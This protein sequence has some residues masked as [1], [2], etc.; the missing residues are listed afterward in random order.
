MDV[1]ELFGGALEAV[2]VGDLARA[3]ELLRD[4]LE[5][6]DL[7]L[8]HQLLGAIAFWDDRLEDARTELEAAFRGFRN[9]GDVCAAARAATNLAELHYGSLGNESAGRGWIGRAKRLLEDA[10]PCVEWGYWELG[11]MACDRLDVDDLARSAA[12]A[13]DIAR[14]Y[15]DPA[16]E[17]RALADSGLAL[18]TQGHVREGFA[19]LDEAL[20]AL[21]SGEVQDTI[22]IGTA[23]CS[24]LSSCDRA[25]E[26]ARAEEWARLVRQQVLDP[27]N[28]RPRVLGTHCELALG[29]VLVAS[30]RTR[31][32][33]AALL[34]CLGPDATASLGHRRDATVRLAELRLQQGRIS[35]AAELLAPIEDFAGAALPLALVHLDRGEPALAVARLRNAVKQLVGDALRAAPMLAALVDAELAAGD[36]DAAQQ[37]RQLLDVLAS[38]SDSPVVAALASVA[39]ARLARAN[40][41]AA[42]AVAA[43]EAALALLATV[44]RPL[45]TAKIHLDLAA[46]QIAAG[47]DAAAIASARA[48]HAAARRL[49][50]VTIADEAGA[51]LRGLGVAPPRAARGP[52][53]L[54]GL[55]P[56]EADVLEGLRRGETNAEIGARLFLAPK[57]VEHHVSRVLAKLGVNNRAAAA[58]LAAEAAATSRP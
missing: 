53:R 29:S 28:Q 7:P 2:G 41:D 16:L 48:A 32:G 25:G 39:E 49:E 11:R 30:G 20:A 5:I 13:M 38:A 47:D 27:G 33:E 23:Y 34:A 50:A 10:G 43:F 4:V 24:L 17:L 8:A 42:A 18:V 35:D 52:D 22:A 21:T 1:G 54:V 31:E 12:R 57:T 46:A 6:D 55:T 58:A 51:V 15:G 3:T 14:E 26:V 40:D 45:L 19:R 44:E 36:P 9:A 37:A 56:R